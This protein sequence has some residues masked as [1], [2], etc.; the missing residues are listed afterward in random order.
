MNVP[1]QNPGSRLPLT[2]HSP[3][4]RQPQSCCHPQSFLS[5]CY[6]LTDGPALNTEGLHFQ[7]GGR[8][9]AGVEAPGEL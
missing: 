2:Q 1:E 9:G 6:T 3:Q 7:W 8:A 5:A 4:L